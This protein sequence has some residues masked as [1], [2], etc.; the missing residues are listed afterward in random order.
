MHDGVKVDP[1]LDVGLLDTA[2][3]VVFENGTWREGRDSLTEVFLEGVISELQALF[4]TIGEQVSVHARMDGL[5]M[6]IQ[7]NA[8]IVVPLTSD[9]TLLFEADNFRDLGTV[10]SGRFEGSAD[11]SS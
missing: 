7:T 11:S 6:L 4:R 2:L 3:D 5:I 9:S 8:I 1:V 10:I